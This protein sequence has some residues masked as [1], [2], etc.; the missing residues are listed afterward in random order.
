MLHEF[1]GYFVAVPVNASDFILLKATTSLPNTLYN[2]AKNAPNIH[3]FNSLDS[4]EGVA[5][6]HNFLQAKF[7]SQN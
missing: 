6:L 2:V 3:G 5:L 1:V 4:Q 7:F